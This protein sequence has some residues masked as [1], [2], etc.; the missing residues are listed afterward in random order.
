MRRLAG[1]PEMLDG[2]L[3]PD[4]LAGNLRDLARVNRWL[5]GVASFRCAPSERWPRDIETLSVLDVGTGDADLPKQLFRSTAYSGPDLRLTA[6][7]IRPEI[8]ELAR[9]NVAR[10][11]VAVKL[12]A[13]DRIDEPDGSFDVVHAS[14][15]LHHLEPGEARSAAARDG[16]RRV[17][18]R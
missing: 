13:P 10:H 11:R 1:F 9:R 5:G 18:A 16:A 4:L 7:D 12:A 6:T 17:P 8:V 15:V 14:L 3:D 2:P